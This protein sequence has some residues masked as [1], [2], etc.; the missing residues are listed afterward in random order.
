M[1][2][3]IRSKHPGLTPFQ[4]KSVLHAAARNAEVER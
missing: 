4:V 1:A 2:A 3:L